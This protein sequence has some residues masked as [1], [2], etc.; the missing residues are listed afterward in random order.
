M[1]FAEVD[2]APN[3][4]DG[5]LQIAQANGIAGLAS[6]TLMFGWRNQPE[7][8]ATQMRIAR[9]AAA[10]DKSTIVCRLAPRHWTDDA[11][12]IDVWWGGLQN[13]GD[14]LLLFAYLIT[15]N[16]SWRS[17]QIR[18]KAIATS[19]MSHEQIETGLGQ[20]LER[21]RIHATT[22]VFGRP[23]AETVQD[24]IHRESRQADVV[25]LGLQT[26]KPGGEVEQ[27]E[28]IAA[29]VEPLPTVIMVHAAGPFAGRLLQDSGDPL[30]LE[31]S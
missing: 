10:V 2:I 6:N 21:T 1:A 8:L 26:P 12:Y 25:F 27:A 3:L 4:E 19:A 22:T 9:R 11:R 16:S 7:R 29:L 28:R 24:V 30:P 13:N 20:L 18:V 5:V 23:Q 31:G 15:A 14:M 17:A